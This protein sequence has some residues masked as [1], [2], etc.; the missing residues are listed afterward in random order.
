MRMLQNGFNVER[1]DGC[2]NLFGLVADYG[3][4][5]FCMERQAGADYVID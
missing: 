1:F 4:D 2:G 3:D 5:F